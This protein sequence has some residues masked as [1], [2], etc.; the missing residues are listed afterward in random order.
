ML[1]GPA[2]GVPRLMLIAIR[3]HTHL[4]PIL[5]LLFIE[6]SLEAE[7]HIVLHQFLGDF[8]HA[9][10]FVVV[11]AVFCWVWDAPAADEGCVHMRIS[12]VLGRRQSSAA[13][14]PFELLVVVPTRAKFEVAHGLNHISNKL[15]LVELASRSLVLVECAGVAL[16]A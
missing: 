10:A 11:L 2:E 13:D 9:V 1:F 7:H 14:D 4:L 16:D 12:L 15:I 8:L 5:L 3:L 6:V